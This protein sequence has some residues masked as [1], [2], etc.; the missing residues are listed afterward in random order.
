VPVYRTWQQLA[1]YFDG[2]GTVYFSDTS[3]QPYKLSLSLVFVDQSSFQASNVREFL[4]GHGVRTSNILK[5]S[6][7]M[8]C[9]LAVSE[10]KSVKL[11]LER[12]APYLCKKESEVRAALRY[13]QGRTTGNE[14]AAVFKEQ[15]E[16]GRRERHPRK[17]PIDVPYKRPDGDRIMKQVRN[18][19]IRDAMGRY[20]AK[21]T[22]E[23]FQAIRREHFDFGRRICDLTREYPQYARETIRRILG[24]GRGYILVKGIGRVDTTDITIR[25]PRRA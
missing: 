20:R 21:L 8:A 11:A 23:D 10:F 15:V 24:R 22:P 9:E 16:A 25:E 19:R 6:D 14:L 1:G 5:R 4:N 7:G 13:Y 12:M 3:N 2:D 17:V 18:D